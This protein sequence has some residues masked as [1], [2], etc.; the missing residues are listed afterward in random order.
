MEDSRGR[1]VF[2]QEFSIDLFEQLVIKFDD[3][4]SKTRKLVEKLRISKTNGTVI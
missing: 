4:T 1:F 2:K 3:T